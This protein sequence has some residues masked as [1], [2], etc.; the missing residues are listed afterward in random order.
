MISDFNDGYPPKFIDPL[1]A[2]SLDFDW[3]SAFRNLDEVTDAEAGETPPAEVLAA[4]LR[5]LLASA[6]GE[7]VNPRNLGLFLIAIGW[8]L[9]PANFEGSPSAA[10][11]AE[12]CGVSPSTFAVYTGEASRVLNWRNRAQRHAWNYKKAV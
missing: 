8:V 4:L 1:D 7:R 6:Q 9:S 10:V 11:L 3:D 12:R 2:P 5:F